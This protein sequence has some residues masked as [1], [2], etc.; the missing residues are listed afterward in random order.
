MLGEIGERPQGLAAGIK[1]AAVAAIEVRHDLA[2][3]TLL[4]S[5]AAVRPAMTVLASR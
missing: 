1:V 5:S 2:L 3:R 4:G